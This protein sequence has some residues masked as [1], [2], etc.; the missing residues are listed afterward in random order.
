MIETIKELATN[1]ELTSYIT[2]LL[3]TLGVTSKD[4]LVETIKEKMKNFFS[5]KHNNPTIDDL[6]KELKEIKELKDIQS[7]TISTAFNTTFNGDIKDSLV[8]SIYNSS[9]SMVF[10]DCAVTI[11]QRQA[12]MGKYI[13]KVAQEKGIPLNDIKELPALVMITNKTAS[14][15]YEYETKKEK[16]KTL[17]KGRIE[18]NVNEDFIQ[19]RTYDRAIDILSK[20][21]KVEL[22]ILAIL[23]I[24]NVSEQ[25]IEKLIPTTSILNEDVLI[26]LYTYILSLFTLI[27]DTMHSNGVFSEYGMPLTFNVQN[28]MLLFKYKDKNIITKLLQSPKL[29]NIKTCETMLN[30][31]YPS[32]I[33]NDSFKLIASIH[34]METI[35]SIDITTELMKSCV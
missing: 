23:H 25:G 10:K 16:L 19:I 31:L 14:E 7:H 32:F 30:A 5:K 3:S 12:D 34:Y 18:N 26:K 35:S 29:A 21:T 28:K 4:I 22:N 27:N 24:F 11:T 6:I 20:L 9:G 2:V 15:G 13:V 17:I 1:G 8:A 33:V